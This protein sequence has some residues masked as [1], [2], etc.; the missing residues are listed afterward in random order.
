MLRFAPVSGPLTE[1]RRTFSRKEQKARFD[2]QVQHIGGK[3]E[4]ALS[5]VN[6]QPPVSGLPGR[7]HRV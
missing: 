4:K 5:A 2:P 6:N 1:L 3:I 7:F